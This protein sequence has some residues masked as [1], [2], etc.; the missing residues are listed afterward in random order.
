MGLENLMF[1][2]DGLITAVVQDVRSNEVLMTA[3]MNKESLQKTIA[4]KTT[5]FYSRSRKK[6]WNKGETSGNFQLVKEIWYDC[7]GDCLLIQVEQVGKPCHTGEKSCFYRPIYRADKRAED[8]SFGDVLDKLYQKIGE[9]RVKPKEGSYTN[10]LLGRGIDKISKKLGEEC[11]E[12][13]LAS[14]NNNQ[15]ELVYEA[16]DLM[17]HLTVLLYERGVDYASIAKELRSRFKE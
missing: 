10:Y 2:E 13:I 6:L 5:W 14:K 11:V 15:D 7:D 3:Y 17:Y 1:D 4:A 12:V 16:S 8:I 9:R